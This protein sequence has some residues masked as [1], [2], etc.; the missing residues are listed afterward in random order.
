MPAYHWH[1]IPFWMQ[2]NGG[3]QCCKLNA[4]GTAIYSYIAFF[5]DR[6]HRFCRCLH[7][8]SGT[9]AGQWL[10]GTAPLAFAY[11]KRFYIDVCFMFM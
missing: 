7:K 11:F 3:G 9:T 4:K 10:C 5:E 8:L 2:C 1:K 6:A